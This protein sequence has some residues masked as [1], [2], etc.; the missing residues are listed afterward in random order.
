MTILLIQVPSDSSPAEWA[1]VQL[2]LSEARQ[3]NP[4]SDIARSAT[5]PPA[6]VPASVPAPIVP[7]HA[8]APVAPI[9]NIPTPAAQLAVELNG[10]AACGLV[11]AHKVDCMYAAANVPPEAAVVI[12]PF[13]APVGDVS[14][15]DSFVTTNQRYPNKDEIATNYFHVMA[16]FAGV[17][18][19]D[20]PE[21]EAIV[22]IA[23]AAKGRAAKAWKSA[24]GGN[25]HAAPAVPPAPPAVQSMNDLIA[26][27]PMPG[28][29]AVASG[30]TPPSSAPA[31]PVGDFSHVSQ[32]TDAQR[33]Q[34]ATY[35]ENLT[36]DRKALLQAFLAGGMADGNGNTV[37]VTADHLRAVKTKTGTFYDK[38]KAQ[39][40]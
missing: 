19:G 31:A 25:G 20:F 29:P 35:S 28:M 22:K 9:I 38:V 32:L 3:A 13:V 17:K 23:R 37:P 26:S 33:A 14:W 7:V 8:V 4:T 30:Q 2:A 27:I 34:V 11:G 39:L 6:V 40:S 21:I 16:R 36:P 24:H 5:P 18:L 12:P 1:Q 10:C 15:F